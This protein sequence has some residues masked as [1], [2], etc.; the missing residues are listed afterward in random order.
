MEEVKEME[1]V[2][3]EVEEMEEVEGDGKVEGNGRSVRGWKKWKCKGMEDVEGDGRCG[4]E[5]KKWKG[6][7]EV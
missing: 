6:M 2:E 1:E 7:E 3:G 4:R 5:W